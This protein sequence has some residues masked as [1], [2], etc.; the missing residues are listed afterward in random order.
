MYQIQYCAKLMQAKCANLVFC[1]RELS[2]KFRA[3]VRM[4][5]RGFFSEFSVQQR[6]LFRRIFTSKRKF[7]ETSRSKASVDCLLLEISRWIDSIVGHAIYIIYLSYNVHEIH[8]RSL[9][10]V[11]SRIQ[12]IRNTRLTYQE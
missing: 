8:D 5:I 2:S 3:K 10:G 1:P 11:K 12:T 6:A 4:T 9:A 7:S